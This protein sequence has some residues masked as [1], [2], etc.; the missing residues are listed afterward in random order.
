MN[1]P[2]AAQQSSP[3]K[4]YFIGLGLG[5]IPV[6]PAWISGGFIFSTNTPSNATVGGFFLVAAGVLSLIELI[7]L[8]VLLFNR[9]LRPVGYGLLTLFL[10]SPIVDVIGC[11]AVN[12][13]NT[14]IS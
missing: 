8:I 13:I 6:V 10:I 5:L 4:L 11:L 1:Q 3:T 9:R 14:S 7:T 12:S 2:P